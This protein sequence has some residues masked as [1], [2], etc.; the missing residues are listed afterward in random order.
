MSHY[1][2]DGDVGLSNS[3]GGVSRYHCDIPLV[4]INSDDVTHRFVQSR[5]TGLRFA[6]GIGRW[7][8][9]TGKALP[10]YDLF[11]GVGDEDDHGFAVWMAAK[12]PQDDPAVDIRPYLK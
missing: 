3:I 8:G 11:D 1:E 2:K 7:L 9:L 4:R 6:S 5:K 12:S 10:V